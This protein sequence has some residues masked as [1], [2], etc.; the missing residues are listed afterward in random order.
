MPPPTSQPLL[1]L[2]PID[3][4]S[5]PTPTTP[6]TT[7]MTMTLYYPIERTTQPTPTPTTDDDDYHNTNISNNGDTNIPVDNNDDNDGDSKGDDVV[8]NF[9]PCSDWTCYCEGG[10]YAVFQYI[11]PT[12]GDTSSI[13]SRHKAHNNSSNNNNISH[14]WKGKLLR[15]DEQQFRTSQSKK[16]SS[17]RVYP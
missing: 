14:V 9:S 1:L 15:I 3:P 13:S 17:D 7:T 2:R 5:P 11:G 4:S 6:T 10:K 12:N 8:Y 16:L